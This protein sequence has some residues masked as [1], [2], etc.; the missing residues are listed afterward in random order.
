MKW[1]LLEKIN[2]TLF[3]NFK[4]TYLVWLLSEKIYFGG[5]EM[6]SA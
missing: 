5:I 6:W 3:V 1:A 4:T 2:L